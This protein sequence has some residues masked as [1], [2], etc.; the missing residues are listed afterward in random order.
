MIPAISEM[1][2]TVS[3]QYWSLI[4]GVGRLSIIYVSSILEI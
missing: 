2:V 1:T 4:R 3:N